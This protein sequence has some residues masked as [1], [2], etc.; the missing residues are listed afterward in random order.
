VTVHD[1]PLVS[2]VTPVYNGA[3]YLKECI[4]SI[5]TQTYSNW[6]YAIVNNCSTDETLK[7]AEQCAGKDSRIRVYSNDKVLDVIA[8]HNK[9]FGLISAESK[10]C[11]VVS[12]DDWLFPECLAR[13]V[14]VAEMNPSVGVVG[15]YQLSGGG[16]NWSAWR[17]KWAALPYP[18]T[19]IPG[20]EICRVRLL[21]G[22]DV[23]V[24][25][26]PTSLLYRAD[27]VR[28]TDPFY[29]NETAEADTSAVYQSLK[30][31]DF[32]FVHQVLSY[33]RIHQQAIGA[34]C[35]SLNTY[36][37]SHL[38]DLINYGP[39]YL[40]VEELNK[41]IQETL[42]DYY[43]YLATSALHSRDE[44][45]WTYH[46][47]RLKDLGHPLSRIRLA[48]VLSIKI[49]DLLLNPKQTAEKVIKRFAVA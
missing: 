14:S 47:R 28:K 42:A 45:F 46:K 33:E 49:L 19:V 22:P 11:K 32:G 15:S 35:R 1:E 39:Y 25:G 16:T 17:I 44:V 31:T 41:S 29:P 8:N 10:Y 36:K 3:L 43:E 37:S 23:G 48:A 27:L 12:A 21:G 4:D 24:F 2:V 7:I 6:E 5:L 13:M 38:S 40:S 20:R 34:E 18:S 9:A 30:D 26:P